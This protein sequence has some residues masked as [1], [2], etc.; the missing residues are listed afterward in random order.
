MIYEG[1][2]LNDKR[3]GKG[4]IYYEESW[5]T[6]KYEG[7]LSDGKKNGKGKEYDRDKHFKYEGVF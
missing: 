7:E 2:Y 1:E 3:N 4:K 6:L 5:P